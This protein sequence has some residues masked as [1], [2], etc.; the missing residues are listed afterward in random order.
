MQLASNKASSKDRISICICTFKRPH[1]LAR[2]LN[3]LTDLVTE[4][5]FDFDIVVVDNDSSQSGKPIVDNFLNQRKIPIKYLEEARQNISYARNKSVKNASGDFIAFID[6][7]E[8]PDSKWLLNL[9]INREKYKADG[10][11]GP[12]KPHFEVEPPKWLIKSK[13]CER[14]SF[15][16]GYNITNY[17]YTRTGNALLKTQILSDLKEPFDPK[18]GLIGGGDADYFKR[19]INKGYTFVWCNEACVYE[20]VTPPR[21]KRS[22]YIQR[23]FTRGA[24]STYSPAI[25]VNTIKSIIAICIY[26]PSLLFLNII[27]HHFFMRYLIKVCDHLGK[28]LAFAGVK[29]VKKRPY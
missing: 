2:L 16:T 25:S 7:D 26:T 6:D 3:S 29:I 23:A 11:L 13:I 5:K 12:V 8:Y 27:G 17:K 4:N 20:T 24:T 9:Y 28:L 22:Y 18:F 19:M 10:V 15:D 14:E 21:F 1:L